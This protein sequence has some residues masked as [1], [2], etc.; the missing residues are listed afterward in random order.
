MENKKNPRREEKFSV[1]QIGIKIFL[2]SN[3]LL[4]ESLVLVLQRQCYD[5][6][7][8]IY[9]KEWRQLGEQKGRKMANSLKGKLQND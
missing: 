5:F 1:L 7:K 6:C 2:F 9:A 8:C 4:I 3:G